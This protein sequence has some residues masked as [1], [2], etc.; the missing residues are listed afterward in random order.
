M[1]S[2]IADDGGLVDHVKKLERDAANRGRD[3][4]ELNM[5]SATELGLGTGEAEVV[6]WYHSIHQERLK[7]Y[8]DEEDSLKRRM[9]PKRLGKDPDG[10]AEDDCQDMQSTVQKAKGELAEAKKELKD[11]CKELDEIK[12]V[13]SLKGTER[14]R[15]PDSWPKFLG[16]LAVVLV[17]ETV[18]NGVFFGANLAGALVGGMTYAVII[19]VVNVVAFGSMAGFLAAWSLPRA[20]SADGVRQFFAIVGLALVLPM[21]VLL[22]LGVAHYREALPGDYPPA[23]M[24]FAAMSDDVAACR[25]GDDETV[26]GREAICLFWSEWFALSDFESYILMLIGLTAFGFA[27]WKWSGRLERWPGYGHAVG[28]KKKAE[29]KLNGLE[30]GFVA[31]LGDS[32][33]KAVNHQEELFIKTRPIAHWRRAND[34]YEKIASRHKQFCEDAEFLQESCRRAIASYR[35]TNRSNRKKPDPNSWQIEWTPNWKLPEIPARPDIGSEDDADHRTDEARS[36]KNELK[37]KLN[38][39]YKQCVIDV[40]R[41]ARPEDTDL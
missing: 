24:P 8:R 14:P 36:A 41:D 19:S 34:A 22:N 17:V 26:A 12:E 13:Y 30:R 25:M 21:G 10:V 29:G 37:K 35:S 39:C 3:D 6:S 32:R 5:P 1:T 4:G 16:I 33:T 2:R 31:E 18:V 11:A 38:D 20:N 9:K 27:A 28:K 40:R 15:V 23:P 7:G